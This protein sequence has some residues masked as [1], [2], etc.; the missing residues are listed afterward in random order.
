[1]K[2][3]CLLL[4]LSL[5][6]HASDYVVIVN[7]SSHVQ[8]ISELQLK[9]VFLK[10]SKIIND[11]TILPINL[12]FSKRARISFEKNIL[13]MSR[14]KLKSFWIQQHYLGKRPPIIMH[15]AKSIIQFVKKITQAIAYIPK[16]DVEDDVRIIYQWRD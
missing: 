3:L 10:K 7:K 15:S 6:L 16:K 14:K 8:N 12:P 13:H 2:K 1:M 9:M 11:T 5:M 4:L